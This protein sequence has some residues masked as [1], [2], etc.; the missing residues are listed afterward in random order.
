LITATE[1]AFARTEFVSATQVSPEL[2]V[3]KS[4]A[5]MNVIILM[6]SAETMEFVSAKPDSW[7]MTAE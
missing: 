1:E 4:P 7:V 5:P 3:I 6:V 2:L